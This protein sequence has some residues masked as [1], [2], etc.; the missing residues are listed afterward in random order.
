MKNVI[1][2]YQKNFKPY[3]KYTNDF[4]INSYPFLNGELGL[5]G[6]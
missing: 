6:L 3:A 5:A 2:Y 4:M 1:V